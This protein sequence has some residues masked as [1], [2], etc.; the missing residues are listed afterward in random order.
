MNRQLWIF[1]KRSEYLCDVG[2]LTKK[3]I[4]VAALDWGLGHATRSVPV[5]RRLCAEGHEVM[6]SSSGRAY[7]FYSQYFPDLKL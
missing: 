2:D 1:A 5:I 4:L 7:D 6:L 3:R